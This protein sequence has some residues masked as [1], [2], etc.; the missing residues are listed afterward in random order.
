[1]G[2]VQGQGVRG[3]AM[4]A[5]RMV[6]RNAHTNTVVSAGGA[7]QTCGACICL[8]MHACLEVARRLRLGQLEFWKFGHNRVP[9][10][11][12]IFVDYLRNARL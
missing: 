4:W 7:F 6:E 11:L 2:D 3:R 1:M 5:M 12:I 10:E 9:S 8:S